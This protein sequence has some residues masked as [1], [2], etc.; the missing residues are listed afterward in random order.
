MNTKQFTAKTISADIIPADINRSSTARDS[1]KDTAKTPPVTAIHD[2]EKGFGH[3]QAIDKVDEFFFRVAKCVTFESQSSV[4]FEGDSANCV[5]FIDNGMVKLINHLPNGRARIVRILGAGTI[6]GLEGMLQQ[7]LYK[8]TAVALGDVKVYRIAVPRLRAFMQ[9][10]CELTTKFIEHW[11]NHLYYADTWITQFSAGAIKSRVARLVNF[12]GIIEYGQDSL[13]VRL[14]TC[15]EMAEVLGVTPE[16]VSRVLAQFKRDRILS[17]VQERPF[18][19]FK[20]D[21]T[22][23]HAVANF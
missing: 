11:H 17:P 8:H 10:D 7:T 13:C 22:R 23:L 21:K 16:S 18:E 3:L 4:Y 15:E 19:V 1:S 20:R 9:R 14:L 6:F 12:L 2:T 5:F